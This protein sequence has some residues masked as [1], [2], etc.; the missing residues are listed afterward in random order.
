MTGGDCAEQ[1]GDDL[2]AIKVEQVGLAGAQ[3]WRR[4]TL[5]VQIPEI[6]LEAVF[7]RSYA[8]D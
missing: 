1:P 8:N 6:Y 7:D 5:D 2:V 4:V 3:G